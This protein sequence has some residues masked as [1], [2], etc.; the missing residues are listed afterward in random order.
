MPLAVHEELGGSYRMDDGREGPCDLVLQVSDVA[1]LLL[2]GRASVRGTFQARGWIESRPIDGEARLARA[3]AALAYRLR[4][5]AAYP[6][7]EGDACWLELRRRLDWHN[8]LHSLSRVVGALLGPGAGPLAEVELRF[9][10]R[11][12]VRGLLRWT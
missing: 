11:R 6:E 9:D 4:L 12:D 5:L 3:N 8:P 2:H 7:C 10:Y 1:G